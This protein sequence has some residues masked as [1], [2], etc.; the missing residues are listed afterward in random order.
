MKFLKITFLALVLFSSNTLIAKEAKPISVKE[1]KKR[2][3]NALVP[4]VNSVYMELNGE[5]KKIKKNIKNPK[6]KKRIQALKETYKVKTDKELL[7]AL[8]PHPKS[9]AIA[10]A[11]IESAWGTSKFYKKAN[12][13]FGVWS[14]NKNEPRIAASQKRKNKTIWLKKY[15]SIRE[16]VKDYYKNI[17]RS[18]AFS[19]F[20]EL[21]MKTDD[22]YKLVKKLNHYSEMKEKYTKE[23]AALIKHNNLHKYDKH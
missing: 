9:I 12:N 11:A 15:P 13:I 17:S 8:K 4:A 7:I 5:Y 14:F 3:F 22:P 6:Y 23:L 2:F 19:E 20:R 18:H 21:K 16:S 10:Q 1:K